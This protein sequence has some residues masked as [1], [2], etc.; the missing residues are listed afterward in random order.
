MKFG[1]SQKISADKF[2]SGICEMEFDLG[3]E[4]DSKNVEH[5]FTLSIH[6]AKDVY[7]KIS[8]DENR[9]IIGTFDKIPFFS[10]IQTWGQSL[11]E[12]NMHKVVLDLRIKEMMSS[13]FNP[14]NINDNNGNF[15]KDF[16]IEVTPVFDNEKKKVK[17][18]IET[19]LEG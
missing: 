15:G 14:D 2:K 8:D 19:G 17:V 7:Y 5:C 13:E 9:V 4:F 6:S 3:N 10:Q 12:D 18:E 1:I 16:I 11:F